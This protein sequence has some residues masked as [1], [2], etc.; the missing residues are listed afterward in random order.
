MPYF[1]NQVK[2]Y[3]L[4]FE[5]RTGS[6]FLTAT[7]SQHPEILAD[8][9]RLDKYRN[10]P[11]AATA[12]LDSARQFLTPPFVGPHRV[13]GFKTKLREIKD[14]TAFA[15]LLQEKRVHI[16]YMQRRNRIKTTVSGFTG[17][18]LYEKTAKWNLT[19]EADRPGAL[20]I[21]P[22]AFAAALKVREER[23]HALTAYVEG[24]A[25]PTLNLYYE[26]LLVDEAAFLAPLYA[27]LGVQPRPASAKT[28]KNTSDDLRQ[29][30][31]NFEELRAP[32][33]GTP[34][35]AMFDE[36]LVPAPSQAGH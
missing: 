18:R 19:Q 22:T 24:L 33:A 34:Y 23:E 9:E 20:H 10:A 15:A 25:L 5:G 11:N 13:R 16:L 36:V 26:A 27:F 4:L 32:Y 29:V 3:V 8:G 35:A 31:V 2:L 6:T 17:Q 28:K 30:L 14:P 12:Q 7:L 21:D 1:R